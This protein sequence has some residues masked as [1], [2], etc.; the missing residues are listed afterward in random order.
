MTFNELNTRKCRNQL[1]LSTIHN[2]AVIVGVSYGTVRMQFLRLVWTCAVLLPSRWLTSRRDTVWSLPRTWS[3]GRE[4]PPSLRTKTLVASR[5]QPVTS[6]HV[7]FSPQTRCSSFHTY[8]TVDM[9]DAIFRKL[10]IQPK[11]RHFDTIADIQ[12][13]SHKVRDA[14]RK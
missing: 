11:G 2:V 8:S 9:I 13:K 12:H 4:Y 7:S 14:F 6:S 1:S 5:R 10:K 3:R